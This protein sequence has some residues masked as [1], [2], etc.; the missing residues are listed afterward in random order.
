MRAAEDLALLADAAREAGAVAMRYW[1]RHPRAWNKSDGTGP[2]TEADLAVNAML[3]QRL[4]NARPG[5]GWLSE[6][7]ADTPDRLERALCFIVDPIDGTRAFIEGQD[8]FAIALGIAEAGRMRAGVVYLPALKRLYAAHSQ[9]RATL[10]DQPLTASPATEPDGARVLTTAPNMAAQHWPGGVPDLRRSF[11]PSLAYRICLVAEG[12]HDA[13]VTFRDAWEW[14]IAAA[15]LIAERAGAIVTDARGGPLQF[16]AAHPQVPGVIA[17]A[18][19]LHGPLL[20]RTRA[21]S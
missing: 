3:A 7:T 1:R 12:R 2:V 9:G 10:N 19:G 17:A 14:D 16:N 20:A 21:A 11:R 5:Y 18:P 15:S 8:T 6:E 13:M 4:R